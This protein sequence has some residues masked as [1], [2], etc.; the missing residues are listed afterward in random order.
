MPGD[1]I[2][3]I[4]PEPGQLTEMLLG[5]YEK[6]QHLEDYLASYPTLLPGATIDPADPRRWL[7]VDAQVGIPREAGGQDHWNVDLLFLDQAGIPTFVELKRASNREIRR[8]IVGQMLDYAANGVTYFSIERLKTLFAKRCEAA[9]K[10]P[11]EEIATLLAGVEPPMEFWELVRSNLASNRVRLVFGADEIPVELQRIVEFLG[12]EMRNVQVLAL[13]VRRYRSPATSM[14]A[15]VPRVVGMTAKARQ[16]KT[17]SGGAS[18][19][20][21]L[22][23]APESVRDFEQQL[24]RWVTSTGLSTRLTLT[25]RAVDTANGTHLLLFYPDN[26]GLQFMLGSI[27]RTPGMEG[28]ADELHVDL[29]RLLGTSVTA[30]HPY[31]SIT[32]V[33]AAWDKLVAEFFPRYV[34]A[35]EQ[36]AA[37]RAS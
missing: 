15:L 5:P 7:L 28:V 20:E 32:A 13:E 1:S 16:A 27:R 35:H 33:A 18:F 4:G 29:E 34:A 12:E 9:G 19:A 22:A 3:L 24:L 23:G 17:A 2:F 25:A 11:A 30:N 6:E 36:A 26:Q 14:D 10:D 21:I 37:R 31:P 8:D